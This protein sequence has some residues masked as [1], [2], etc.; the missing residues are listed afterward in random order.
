V[1]YLKDH[2]KDDIIDMFICTYIQPVPLPPNQQTQP[3][4]PYVSFDTKNTQISWKNMQYLWKHFLNNQ[5]LP[6]IMFQQTLKDR[7]IIMLKQQ[8]NEDADLF[9]GI[10]SKYLPIIQR[11]LQFW[12]E[13]VIYDELEYD[14]EI[15]ELTGL[16]KRWCDASVN[17]YAGSFNDR[18]IL[19]IIG[20][21]FPTIEIYKDK[22]I[23]KI[24]C[25][26]WD[27]HFEIHVALTALKDDLILK[28][29]TPGTENIVF[30]YDA[31]LYY[32]NYYSNNTNKSNTY[33]VS[34]SYFEKHVIDNIYDYISFPAEY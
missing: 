22:Y 3:L 8:Y 20:Y 25:N 1:F 32:C 13:T 9:Q 14:F 31:Y 15:D 16:F 6:N 29:E 28:Q 30:I 11:F 4:K 7:L 33:I 24:R 26:L 5:N 21:Y 23:Q 12:E 19:D 2:T 27:K 10:F 17:F 34:K 18:T